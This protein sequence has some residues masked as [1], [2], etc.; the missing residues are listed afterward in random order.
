MFVALLLLYTHAAAGSVRNRWACC[1]SG[2]TATQSAMQI[3]LRRGRAHGP[4]RAAI[5]GTKRSRGGGRSPPAPRSAG[6]P[7][8]GRGRR[9]GSAALH[10]EHRWRRTRAGRRVVVSRRGLTL[11]A[12]LGR[13][14]APLMGDAEADEASASRRLSVEGPTTQGDAPDAPLL[15]SGVR[16]ATTPATRRHRAAHPRGMPY[17]EKALPPRAARRRHGG[18]ASSPRPPP[19]PLA[20]PAPSRPRRAGRKACGDRMRARRSPRQAGRRGGGRRL[21]LRARPSRRSF[22]GRSRTRSKAR[23]TRR[24]VRDELRVRFLEG[25]P[26]A[27]V[28]RARRGQC[29]RPPCAPNGWRS[30]SCELGRRPARRCRGCRVWRRDGR[31]AWSLRGA[32]GRRGAPRATAGRQYRGAVCCGCVGAA[33]AARVA[34]VFAVETAFHA[35][36]TLM[37]VIIALAD[38]VREPPASPARARLRRRRTRPWPTRT[39]SGPDAHPPILRRGVGSASAHL[40]ARDGDARRAARASRVTTQAT[41]PT[42]G[43]GST[44]SSD[45]VVAA[46]VFPSLDN[47]SA[48][49]AIRARAGSHHQPP[50]APQGARRSPRLGQ[51]TAEHTSALSRSSD[52]RAAVFISR[53]GRGAA[54]PRPSCP[55][56]GAGRG[57]A[58]CWRISGRCLPKSSGPRARPCPRTRRHPSRC[59]TR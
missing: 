39:L 48:I 50:A 20:P 55:T 45:H 14:R 2:S 37:A 33:P 19:L 34:A 15:E 24:P 27:L 30:T 36:V 43:I 53:R 26:R 21:R 28:A 13:T 49:R 1:L 16:A 22:V 3:A 41:S 4:K 42:R 44:A 38:G 57:P 11:D 52:V 6:Q 46:A 35:T 23:R 25:S 17:A 59:S 54:P 47:Y 18:E 40:H 7:V 51:N 5:S 9:L 56:N 32:G 8:R 31:S 12:H 29:C 58:R 10:G